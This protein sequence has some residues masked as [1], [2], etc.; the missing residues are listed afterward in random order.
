MGQVGDT[1]GRD[2]AEGGSSP[3]DDAGLGLV[4][5]DNL[6]RFSKVKLVDTISLS[7]PNGLVEVLSGSSLVGRLL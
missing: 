6:K 5:I 4:N 3:G 7:L 1:V 2:E